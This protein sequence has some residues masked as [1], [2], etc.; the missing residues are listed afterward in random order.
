VTTTTHPPAPPRSLAA[1]G[2]ELAVGSAALLVLVGGRWDYLGHFLAGAG[3]ALGVAAVALLAGWS[4]RAVAVVAAVVPV[5]LGTLAELVLFSRL[6]VD[7]ADVGAGG[8]G[9]ALVGA[10]LLAEAPVAAPRRLLVVAAALVA[11][12]LL[13]RFGLDDGGL[14]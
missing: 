7:W 14:L 3:T 5:V 8:L 12:G 11:A 2:V 4:A 13:L 9:A 1:L 6:L 10:H